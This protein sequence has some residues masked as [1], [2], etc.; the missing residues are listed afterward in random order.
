MIFVVLISIDRERPGA[1]NGAKKIE[2]G[3]SDTKIFEL[4]VELSLVKLR[5]VYKT[6]SL[7]ILI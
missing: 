6:L 5:L 1:S 4:K 7:N 2:I 3:Q